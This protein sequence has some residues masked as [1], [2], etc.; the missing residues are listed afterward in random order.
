MR[1]VIESPSLYASRAGP[2][3]NSSVP[4]ASKEVK[5]GSISGKG[6]IDVISIGAKKR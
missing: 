2:M 4:M 3:A 6:C 1:P 5:A